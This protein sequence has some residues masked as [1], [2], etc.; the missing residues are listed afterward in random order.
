MLIDS[1]AHLD[2]PEFADDLPGVLE[3]ARKNGVTRII[4]I[5][6]DPPSNAAAVRLAASYPQI[7][8]AVGIHPHDS[9]PLGPEDLEALRAAAGEPKVLAIG[10]A[11]LD[12]YWNR[13]PR[14][15]Q[16]SCLRMQ[17]V[18]AG[19]LGLPVVFHI[20]DAFDDFFR[21]A[22]DY[23]S[24]LPGSIL[25]CFSGDWTIAR[26]CLDMGFYLSMPGTV[27]FAKAKAQQEVARL[28]PLDRL[29]V[30]TDSPYLAPV[31]FRGKVNEPSYVLHTARKIAEL[32]GVELEELAAATTANTIRAFHMPE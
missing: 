1:H 31:P 19:E 30:E 24:I 3:R 28:A 29:L 12:Y 16:E 4:T 7:Y 20:R 17:I 2:F 8:A 27:T 22:A 5:G 21:I 32:R 18:L 6:V 10:E 14:D 26:R 25:H 9:R 11:G 13:Q 23:A 15:V